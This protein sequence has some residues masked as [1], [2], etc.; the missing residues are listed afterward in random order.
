MNENDPFIDVAARVLA[1]AAAQDSS[2]A[3][4]AMG[5]IDKLDVSRVRVRVLVSLDTIPGALVYAEVTR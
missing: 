2:T 3:H 5:M 1:M 4:I